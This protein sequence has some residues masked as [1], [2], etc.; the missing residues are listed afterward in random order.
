[1]LTAVAA[2]LTALGGL[3]AVL[4]NAGLLGRSDAAAPAPVSGPVAPPVPGTKASSAPQMIGPVKGAVVTGVDG[5][6]IRLTQLHATELPF[7][8]GQRIEF[9]RVARLDIGQPWD[10]SV[11]VTL[12]NGQQLQLGGAENLLF[13]G[14]NELG[15]YSTSLSSLRRIEFQR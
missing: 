11:V 13:G 7:K 12:V 6:E 2:L 15:G 8:S 3:L 14:R 9:D 10:G 5:S 4:V 1:M